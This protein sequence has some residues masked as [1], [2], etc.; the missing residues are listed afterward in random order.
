MARI[1]TVK[2][3]FWSHP[4][5][6]RMAD[7][8]KTM[9]IALLN[10][11]D[12]EGFFLADPILVRNFARPFDDDSSI[13][14][15]SLDDLSRIGWISILDNPSH[16]PIGKVVNFKVHQRIDRPKPSKLSIYFE[17]TTNRRL[18]DEGSTEE[19]KGKEGNGMG[20]P[21]SHERSK[22]DVYSKHGGD[23]DDIAWED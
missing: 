16:G 13:T 21:P 22:Q 1:R 17:S 14:R 15:R 12:D 20:N 23:D 4:I 5:L 7:S 3:E 19:R 10:L 18:V 11:A 9:A 8:T 6:G 2:P